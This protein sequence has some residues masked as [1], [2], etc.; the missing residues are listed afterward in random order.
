[1]EEDPSFGSWLEVLKISRKPPNNN[2]RQEELD[3]AFKVA[4]K[5]GNFNLKDRGTVLK[6]SGIVPDF[7]KEINEVNLSEDEMINHDLSV[8]NDWESL[9]SNVVGMACFEKHK[10]KLYIWNI[11]LIE[12]I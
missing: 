9:K 7:L 2:F 12:K 8:F 10:E 6:T 3:D 4:L 5:I 1:M 11:K